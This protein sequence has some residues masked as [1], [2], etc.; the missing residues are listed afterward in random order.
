LN[1]FSASSF[2]PGRDDSVAFTHDTS[3][4]DLETNKSDGADDS[5]VK[6]ERDYLDE[7]EVMPAQRAP[8]KL[9]GAVAVEVG[10]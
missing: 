4:F 5:D 7:P 1:Y 3:R 9:S 2:Y 8:S 6:S 10:V